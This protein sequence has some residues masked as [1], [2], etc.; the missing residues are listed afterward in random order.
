MKECPVCYVNA[1]DFQINCGHSFCYHCIKKWYQE[2]KTQTCPLCRDYMEFREVY[3][4]C[5]TH[6]DILTEISKFQS[7]YVTLSRMKNAT[8]HFDDVM[9][10]MKQTWC[11]IASQNNVRC[12]HTRYIFIDYESGT[13]IA[14]YGLRL[15]KA[16]HQKRHEEQ[17]ID[18][19]TETFK[20]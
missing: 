7:T 6:V 4:E 13:K 2:S 8:V 5:D 15:Q 9:Y 11:L 12:A 17:E 20:E 16:C 10:F 18:L 1:P 3:V 19:L 14:E